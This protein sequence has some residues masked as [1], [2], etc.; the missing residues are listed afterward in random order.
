[1][2]QDD[3]IAFDSRE[4]GWRLETRR[5]GAVGIHPI[6]AL[7]VAAADCGQHRPVKAGRV[8]EAAPTVEGPDADGDER[9]GRRR[10]NRA[11]ARHDDRVLTTKGRVAA[12]PAVRLV[13]CRDLTER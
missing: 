9:L 4:W 6:C 13:L 2:V 11:N 7:H 12:A 5:P 8:G 10:P 1:V 3:E